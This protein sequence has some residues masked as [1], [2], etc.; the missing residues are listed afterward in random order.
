MPVRE[1][2]YAHVGK[3]HSGKIQNNLEENRNARKQSRGTAGPGSKEAG[4]AVLEVRLTGDG[5]RTG[6]DSITP[7]RS[8]CAGGAEAED[9]T[10][11]GYPEG[12][13]RGTESRGV[14][15]LG[16]VWTGRRGHLSERVRRPS[17]SHRNLPV[18]H[19]KQKAVLFNS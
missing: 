6:P 17:Y 2:I 7:R 5:W 14:R 15:G 19:A 12:A 8:G 4:R 3:R 1:S 11:V 13:S 16:S 10:A 18:T 9:G